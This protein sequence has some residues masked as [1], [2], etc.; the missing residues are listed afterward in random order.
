ML[1]LIS[2]VVFTQTVSM[3]ASSNL[4]RPGS[5]A[6]GLINRRKSPMEK[7]K[8]CRCL[9]GSVDHD[10]LRKD[11]DIELNRQRKMGERRWNFNFDSETPL[12]GRYEWTRVEEHR[13][14]S[15]YNS[16]NN[17][18]KS[19]RKY[20][21]NPDVLNDVDDFESEFTPLT[22][23]AAERLSGSIKCSGDSSVISSANT[24]LPYSNGA[25]SMSIS[26]S[27]N[28]NTSPQSGPRLQ[29]KISGE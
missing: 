19:K 5:I 6:L 3:E 10:E 17:G 11:L 16:D 13:V 24:P 4:N 26:H 25:T 1:V 29:S 7:S 21:T 8:V 23:D 2:V 28:N 15:V 9:F 22:S 14:P 20:K 18:V 27:E 12:E